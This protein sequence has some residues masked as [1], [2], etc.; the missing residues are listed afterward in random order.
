MENV[1]L[2]S[3][4]RYG[5]QRRRIV[6]DTRRATLSRYGKYESIN[7]VLL[8]F[9]G[10]FLWF[11]STCSAATQSESEGS[12]SGRTSFKIKASNDKKLCN[13]MGKLFDDNGD[14]IAAGKFEE[15][16]IFPKWS[17]AKKV[18][19]KTKNDIEADTIQEMW[20]DLN[21][22]KTVDHVYKTRL[23]L[24]GA[25][26]E[27]FYILTPDKESI[28]LDRGI[29][30]TEFLDYSS[31][32]FQTNF[33]NWK[34]LHQMTGR[35]DQKEIEKWYMNPNVVQYPF[36]FSGKTFVAAYNV[37]A[38]ANIEANLY[39]FSAHINKGQHRIES[40]CLF[41]KTTSRL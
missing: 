24:R 7:Y 12:L 4:L 37:F 40:V 31:S 22:D 32:S 33:Q 28:A 11:D 14:A 29:S 15:V 30:I 10:L 17:N 38:P 8:A 41:R 35:K 25:R 26:D 1:A 27:V 23:S 20:I 39:I 5:S 3:A 16:A 13:E 18:D 19:E 2:I 36:L 9:V 21:N 6:Q 34:A